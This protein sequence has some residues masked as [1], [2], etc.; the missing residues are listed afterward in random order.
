M[1]LHIKPKNDDLKGKNK[2][3]H[4]VRS[5]FERCRTE[6]NGEEFRDVNTG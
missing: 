1:N 3:E 5:D 4:L 6:D 2:R